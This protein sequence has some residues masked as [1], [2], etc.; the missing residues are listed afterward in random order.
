MLAFV[1]LA[2]A[3]FSRIYPHLLH[4]TGMNFTAVGGGLLFFG[5]QLGTHHATRT[6]TALKFLAGMAALAATDYYLTVYAYAYPFHLSGYVV[7][8]LWY[9]G[10][11]LLGMGMLRKP[12]I[13]R[14]A[15]GVL[16]SATSFFLVSN[17]I[18]WAGGHMYAPT[19]AGLSSCYLAAI[20][21]YRNDVVSTAITAGALFGLPA[22]AW[23]IVESLHPERKH[24]QL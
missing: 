17:F 4:G 5:S 9:A 21:F 2:I 7:T 23:R 14:V 12:S 3:I 13:L 20:P 10:V 16:A 19:L 1:V 11:C 8:W 22:L 6:R 18:V 24:A 15:A